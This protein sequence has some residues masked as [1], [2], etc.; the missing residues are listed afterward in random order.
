MDM[1]RIE[2]HLERARLAQVRAKR[3]RIEA[4]LAAARAADLRLRD[5][6][7]LEIHL[8]RN[9]DGLAAPALD[10]ATGSC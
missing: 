2:A 6:H 3:A 5:D 1:D 10:A 8:R 4:R 9:I 7:Q